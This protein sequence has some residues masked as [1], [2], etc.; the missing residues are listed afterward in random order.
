MIHPYLDQLFF[1]AAH[2]N[3]VMFVGTGTHLFIIVDEQRGHL[4]Q[5]PLST[6]PLYRGTSPSAEVAVARKAVSLAVKKMR[7]LDLEDIRL[8]VKTSAHWLT[9]ASAAAGPHSGLVLQLLRYAQQNDVDLEF[10]LVNPSNNPATSQI[11]FC[12][13][14]LKMGWSNIDELAQP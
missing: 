4:E 12:E 5:A 13:E 7:D 9:R 14:A 8:T 6:L 2:G 3:V 1:E 11:E 10:E